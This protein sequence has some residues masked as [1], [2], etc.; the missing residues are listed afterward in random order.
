MALVATEML[1][2]RDALDGDD[3]VQLGFATGNP[4]VRPTPRTRG[5]RIPDALELVFARALA[6][7]PEQRYAN[8]GEFLEAVTAVAIELSPTSPGRPTVPSNPGFGGASLVQP[9][10]RTVLDT[11]V[12]APTVRA[13]LGAVAA[14][15]ARSNPPPTLSQ[16][17]FQQG[18]VRQSL[19]SAPGAF[20]PP[21][22][23][24]FEASADSSMA[25]RTARAGTVSVPVPIAPPAPKKGGWFTA[26]L[27]LFVLVGAATAVYAVSG[28]RGS[29]ETKQALL[30]VAEGAKNVAETAKIA[31]EQL[32]AQNTGATSQGSAQHNNGLHNADVG[33]AQAGS[34]VLGAAPSGSA[35]VDGSSGSASAGA[36]GK[37]TTQCPPQML[38]IA[39]TEFTLGSDAAA[40]P[41]DSH[42]AHGV[43]LSG[44]C[45]DQKEV[46]TAQYRQC[47]AKGRCSKPAPDVN[48]KAITA[49]ERKAY[50]GLCTFAGGARGLHPV[51]CV[52][53]AQAAAYCSAQG[54]RLPTEA[55]WEYAARGKSARLYPWG[56][57]EPTSKHLNACGKEC[58]AWSSS[59]SLGLTLL[60]PQSDGFANLAPVG[61]FPL[62]RSSF[63]LDDMAGNAAEWVSDRY[64]AYP[65]RGS[66]DEALDNPQGPDT[67]ERRVVRGGS[68]TSGYA[69][70]YRSLVRNSELE[71]SVRADLGF[72]CAKS[73]P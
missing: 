46:T 8:A 72:R 28:L 34:N 70:H 29:D 64:G 10:D 49:N 73:T 23:N 17:G 59:K 40:D 51:N 30:K 71:T 4:E 24:S 37:P 60:Y 38:A 27:A 1:S 20:G 5:A 14:L 48:W 55:E 13:D 47:V 69:S 65:A 31:A 41:E 19:A 22:R 39:S 9:M 68:Y 61:S 16:P 63:G 67:G 3:L 11:R 15:T 36:T 42:P 44:Y 58:V 21:E 2:G 12:N 7:H 45:I 18:P 50:D 57:D 52:T 35:V 53:W 32:K 26:L 54:A 43:S 66:S 25:S 56:D 6:V 33:N 62:G